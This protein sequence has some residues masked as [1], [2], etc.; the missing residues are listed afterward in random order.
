MPTTEYETIPQP[1][2]YPI[3]GHLSYV[4]PPHP[5]QNMMALA[6]EY[7]PIYRLHL[8]EQNLVV[9]SSQE[10][11]NEACDE[12]R[13]RKN[14]GSSLRNL[15]PAAGDGLF[16][17]WTHEPNWQ[18]AHNI[19][20]PNF[21]TKAMQGYLPAMIDMTEQL[22]QKWARLNFED[23]VNVVDDMTRVTL[24]TI[25]MCGFN[26]RFNSFYRQDSHPFVAS[27]LRVLTEVLN[28]LGRLPGQSALMPGVRAQ[29]QADIAFM[30][31]MVDKIIEERKASGPEG[32]KQDL[33]GY[34]LE[35][36]DKQTG[37]KL[38]DV[39]IR[40]QMITFLAAGHET[41]SGLLSFAIYF[42]LKN[43][44]ILA[45]AHEEMD[46]VLG[47]DLDTM[48][49]YAQ[50]NHF[51][52]IAQILK[53]TLRMWPTAPAFGLYPIEATTLG[54]KYQINADD[55]L[56]V[57][58]P[59]LHRDPKIWGSDRDVFDPDRFTPEREAALPP[60]SYKP[61]GNG[62]R[63]CIG[64]QFAMQEATLVLGM[65]LH[66]FELDDYGHYD[67]EVKETLTL[68]PT[69]FHI[70]VYPRQPHTVHAAAV[71][72]VLVAEPARAAVAPAPMVAPAHHTPLLVLFGSNMG[73]AEGVAQQIGEA[74]K[75]LNFAV[76][77]APLDDFAGKLP[78][79][80]A[81]LIVSSSYNGTP[82]DNAVKFCRWLREEPNQS[83]QLR[84]VRYAV[85][86]CGNRDWA[87]T[88]QAVPK[89]I[90]SRLEALGARRLYARGE[91]DGRDDFDG[92]FH[93][94]YA[95]LW[96]VVAREFSLELASAE[97]ATSALFNVEVVPARA[98]LPFL[99][100]YGAQP[101]TVLANREL[102][103]G[104]G[105]QPPER[106]TRH[107]EIALPQGVTYQA[108][109]YL[110]V[111][112]RHSDERVRRVAARV[113]VSPDSFVR[114]RPTGS[115]KTHLPVDQP[116]LV[117]EL[118]AGYVELQEPAT[119]TQIKVLA[120]HN[121]CPPENEKLLALS[122][123]DPESAARYREAVFTPRKSLV[124]L[125]D[126]FP[127]TQLPLSVLLELLPPLK[128]RYYS[129]SSSPR[130]GGGMCSLTVAVLSGPARSGRG[131]FEGVC[132]G[133][134]SRLPAGSQVHA[135]VSDPNS[136]FHLPADPSIPIIMIG[137][138]TGFAPMR[139]FLQ[140][141]A[142]LQA[143]GAT[144]GPALLFCGCRHPQQDYIYEEDLRDWAARGVVQVCPAF[145]RLPGQ[146]KRYV[147]DELRARQDAVWKLIESGAVVYVCGDARSMAPGVRQA[148][149]DI[150]RAKT[151]TSEAVAEAW[152]NDLVASKRYLTDVW[153]AS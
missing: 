152:L 88:Y 9:I 25:G 13:F 40:Y 96:P 31:A 56:S 102:Q 63:A 57:S 73:T 105:A 11:V 146:P 81:V 126:E 77:T 104:L 39:N 124:D 106:S 21:S 52:Y 17:S 15:R 55:V 145:S 71:A 75:A 116:I 61:F 121:E 49:T 46:R 110:G 60:N 22:L 53:E 147:Q 150:F 112:P 100:A 80:G 29:F 128:P 135:F 32:H 54:G 142:A 149:A 2:A 151:A 33:L 43:P 79:E 12:Q 82:P 141:R 48:P 47:G 8:P 7:G 24:D 30:N 34:M 67:L 140:E 125:L 4:R 23:D 36:V 84:G 130:A 90:D 51:V 98:A 27:M 99:E 64:R 120:D 143:A 35:G 108:G 26:Y 111:I 134:L 58:I 101:M 59:M 114:I 74:A 18:K 85:F 65:I 38:D 153:A 92:Q 123:S 97:A 50:V 113:N 144:L 72:P 139:G 83:G 3:I 1:P 138:G 118:L 131:A 62:L 19:L 10:L 20:L 119:R 70:K 127:A 89:L 66:R 136:P 76:T 115:E 16:T 137:P 28:Q 103:R 5:I 95:P 78:A 86:G 42:L 129:I 148:F 45:R 94:W 117:S 87:G 122:G 6:R 107:I 91:G 109:D 14:V 68:K 69:N 44:H 37:E 93:D 41:T 133:Y 132:S